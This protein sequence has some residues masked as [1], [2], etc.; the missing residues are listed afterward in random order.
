MST[1]DCE[2][3]L[4]NRGGTLRQSVTPRGGVEMGSEMQ[5]RALCVTHPRRHNARIDVRGGRGAAAGPELPACLAPGRW[6]H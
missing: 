6:G 3:R 1:Q 2:V 4:G 5:R